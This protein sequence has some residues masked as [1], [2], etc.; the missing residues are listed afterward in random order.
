MV[1]VIPIFSTRAPKTD[2]PKPKKDILKQNDL[3]RDI[4]E[5]NTP[6]SESL[7]GEDSTLKEDTP[8]ST[9]TDDSSLKE[10]TQKQ[11]L[12]KQPKEGTQKGDT[13]QDQG[14]G[15]PA[16]QPEIGPFSFSYHSTSPTTYYRD[17]VYRK[18]AGGIGEKTWFATFPCAKA[19]KRK[20]PGESGMI[21]SCL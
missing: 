4:P 1:E 20:T 17:E 14:S 13:P 7:P 10:D 21:K 8:D 2:D 15:V 19:P 12:P 5:D 3:M 16:E 9:F 11:H 18:F 6:A